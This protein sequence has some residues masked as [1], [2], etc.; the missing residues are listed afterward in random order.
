VRSF[1]VLEVGLLLNLESSSIA[2]FCRIGV[3]AGIVWSLSLRQSRNFTNSV[4]KSVA[5]FWIQY[6]F[7][8]PAI[9]PF[10]QL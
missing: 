4:L 9:S 6:R 1:A 2:V 7:I 8:S 3:R 10:R 5:L